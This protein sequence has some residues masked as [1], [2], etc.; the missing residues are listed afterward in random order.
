MRACVQS[1]APTAETL[2]HAP[3]TRPD[4]L[5]VSHYI[6]RM[7]GANSL[8]P[9]AQNRPFAQ[10]ALAAVGLNTAVALAL[11]AGAHPLGALARPWPAGASR[12]SARV[13]AYADGNGVIV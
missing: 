11:S 4:P 3:S 13:G 2:L 5:S 7:A 12:V 10:P 6:E 8:A 1:G 9:Y